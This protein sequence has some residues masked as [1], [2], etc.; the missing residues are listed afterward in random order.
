VQGAVSSAIANTESP[1]ATA[2][3]ARAIVERSELVVIVDRDPSDSARITPGALFTSASVRQFY[4]SSMMANRSGN[5]PLNRSP[6]QMV[7]VSPSKATTAS[8]MSP[9]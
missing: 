7:T 8:A 6:Q 1:E 5:R 4:G 2:N 3:N 9:H